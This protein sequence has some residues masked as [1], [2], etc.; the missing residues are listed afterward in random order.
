MGRNTEDRPYK[1]Y[2]AH[3]VRCA[4]PDHLEMGRELLTL[5]LSFSH[6]WWPAR[7]KPYQ[8]KPAKRSWQ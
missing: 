1:H 2:F 3:Y 4:Y 7:Q 5:N 6:G 8:G